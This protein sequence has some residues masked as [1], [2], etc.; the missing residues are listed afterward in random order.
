MRGV[1]LRFDRDGNRE[2]WRLEGRTTVMQIKPD[3]TRESAG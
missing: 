3:D 1:A 2:A